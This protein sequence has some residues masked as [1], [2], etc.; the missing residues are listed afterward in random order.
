MQYLM[1]ALWIAALLAVGNAL[2]NYLSGVVEF[3]D[4]RWPWH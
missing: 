1:I 4:W 2:G 3:R